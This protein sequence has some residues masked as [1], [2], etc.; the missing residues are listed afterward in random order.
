MRDRHARRTSFPQLEAVGLLRLPSHLPHTHTTISL[1][2][3]EQKRRNE[4]REP[5]VPSA[6]PEEGPGQRG[7]Y[8]CPACVL[9][10]SIFPG[11]QGLP[12]L[13]PRTTDA[14]KEQQPF[15]SYLFEEQRFRLPIELVAT[16][17]TVMAR[18]K[19]SLFNNPAVGEPSTT[20]QVY[21]QRHASADIRLH[22]HI[23]LSTNL[24]EPLNSV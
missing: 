1:A 19:V 8:C 7:F 10:L 3:D 12:A 17:L 4:A 18:L 2:I 24:T 13:D 6:M 21:S 16:S 22:I 11:E 15:A 5:A 14:L 23:S 20:C 9:F